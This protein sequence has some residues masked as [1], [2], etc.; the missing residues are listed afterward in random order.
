MNEHKGTVISQDTMQKYLAKNKGEVGQTVV[1]LRCFPVKGSLM[2]GLYQSTSAGPNNAFSLTQGDVF[3]SANYDSRG[4]YHT[5]FNTASGALGNELGVSDSL[6]MYLATF[7]GQ[8]PDYP[9]YG[10]RA[11]KPRDY[12]IVVSVAENMN[13]DLKNTEIV[14]SYVWQEISGL[15]SMCNCDGDHMSAQKRT[16]VCIALEMLCG[17]IDRVSRNLKGRVDRGMIM[18]INNCFVQQQGIP[19]QEES[20]AA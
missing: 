16:I 7:R 12:H 2:V 8:Y 9:R 6:M 17:S 14:E 10:K 4:G 18:G 19:P 13:I 15:L 11:G 20:V 3:L 1:I 5:L